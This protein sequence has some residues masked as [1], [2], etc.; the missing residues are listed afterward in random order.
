[1]NVTYNE[2]EHPVLGDGQS[3]IEKMHEAHAKMEA[4]KVEFDDEPYAILVDQEN[5]EKLLQETQHTKPDL[6]TNE[7]MLPILYGIPV[8]LQDVYAYKVV[9]LKEYKAFYEGN[10]QKIKKFAV[11]ESYKPIVLEPKPKP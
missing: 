6:K 8:I 3:M 7:V 5:F 2:M 10:V 4:I 11:W 1:M 9:T